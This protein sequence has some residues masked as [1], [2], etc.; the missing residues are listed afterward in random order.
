VQQNDSQKFLNVIYVRHLKHLYSI[1]WPSPS[2]NQTSVRMAF[3]IR[4]FS[5][6]KVQNICLR[7]I[8]FWPGPENQKLHR[9][10]FALLVFNCVC[11]IIALLIQLN[12][13]FNSTANISA[14]VE[15]LVSSITGISVIIKITVYLLKHKEFKE[16][17]ATFDTIVTDGDAF[18]GC[19]QVTKFYV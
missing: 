17:L 6:F 14:M 1:P 15:S 10:Y 19:C 5:L 3:K 9:K 4:P 2:L 11:T 16:L 12:F 13:A 7:K 8:G 18:V